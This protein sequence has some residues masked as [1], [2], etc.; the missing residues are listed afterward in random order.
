MICCCY[1][2]WMAVHGSIIAT[3]NKRPPLRN[4]TEWVSINFIFSQFYLI[5]YPI[6]NFKLSRRLKN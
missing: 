1:P 5:D 2:L 6:L 3:P 4:M